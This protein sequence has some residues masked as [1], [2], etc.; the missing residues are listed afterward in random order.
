MNYM[1]SVLIPIY[2]KEKLCNKMDND[3]FKYPPTLFQLI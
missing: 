2:I 3:S 1:Q